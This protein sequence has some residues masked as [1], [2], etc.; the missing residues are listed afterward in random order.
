MLIFEQCHQFATAVSKIWGSPDR[1][2][3]GQD[4]E[5]RALCFHI[6]SEHTKVWAIK[7]QGVHQ[8]SSVFERNSFLEF[9]LQM[10]KPKRAFYKR[11]G[12]WC[13]SEIFSG[14]TF[15]Q[16][17]EVAETWPVDEAPVNAWMLLQSAKFAEQL[18]V[19]CTYIIARYWLL[20]YIVNQWQFLCS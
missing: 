10:L 16:V 8:K 12:T 14:R 20:Y 9:R 11:L 3:L 6:C 5:V 1:K 17:L 19:L 7:T 15:C 13:R 2:H 18:F 4:Q